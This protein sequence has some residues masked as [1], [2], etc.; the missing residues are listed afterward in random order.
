[1]DMGNAI[2]MMGVYWMAVGIIILLLDS[3]IINEGRIYNN[4]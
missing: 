4:L 3:L 1:M 2:L